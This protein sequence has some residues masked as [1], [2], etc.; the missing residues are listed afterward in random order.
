MWRIKHN[1]EIY[2]LYDDVTISTSFRL[3]RLAGHVVKSG[4]SRIPGK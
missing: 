1:E 2:K 4:D 3:R